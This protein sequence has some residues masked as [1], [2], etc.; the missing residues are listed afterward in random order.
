MTEDDVK[1]DNAFDTIPKLMLYH[2]KQRGQ[3][4]AN[5]QKE[6]GI[7]KSWTWAEVADE[8][9]RLACGLA[10]LGFQRGDKL[11]VIGN[12]R[13]RLYWSMVATQVLGGF[14]YRFIRILLRKRCYTFLKMLTLS[15]QL[16]RTKNRQT[17]SLR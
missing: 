1:K 13:P 5:R 17:N 4:P 14:L 11:A 10:S 2:S 3:S 15:M 8:V 12:N 7:W 6:L 16:C 9:N